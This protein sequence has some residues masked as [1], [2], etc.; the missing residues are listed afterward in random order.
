MFLEPIDF[1]AMYR[2]HKA[3]TD[4]KSKTSTD[5][6]EKSADMAASTINSPYVD[7]FISRMELSGDEVILDIGCGPGALSI[8]LAKRVKEVIAIDFSAQM[9]AELEAYATRE[10]ISN[11]KTYHIGWEDDWSILPSVDIAVASRSMEVVDMKKA[12][13]KM[14]SHARKKCYLTYKVGGSFVDLEILS[15]IGKAI[16][17]KPDFWYIP[18][19]LYQDSYLPTID[20]ITTNRGSIRSASADE[21]IESL[22]WSLGGLDDVQLAKAKEYY[23]SIILKEGRHPKPVQW[24]FI[25]WETTK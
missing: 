7:D 9:L 17:M 16:K 6:D 21:F 3:T 18:I 8:P 19:I 15:A 24:A 11:I 13:L 4:F 1:A 23:E 22:N 2:E 10:G 12:L 14:S 20:Y 5:W 25:A